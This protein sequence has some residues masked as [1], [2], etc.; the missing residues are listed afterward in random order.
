VIVD[1][2]FIRVAE[3]SGSATFYNDEFEERF[4]RLDGKIHKIVYHF[5]HNLPGS[6]KQISGII[7]CACLTVSIYLID[8]ISGPVINLRGLF[9]IPLLIGAFYFDR[10]YVY[11]NT[12]FI[13]IVV[14][15]SFRDSV[16]PNQFFPFLMTFIP[17]SVGLGL[18]AQFVLMLKTL[19]R[20]LLEHVEDLEGDV[21]E[22]KEKIKR[23]SNKET[24]V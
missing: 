16:F 1:K 22:L 3:L 10:I 9:L 5:L 24:E 13:S 18:T 7:F 2:A 11:I 6:N 15:M 14:T 21:E 12:F 19:I 23:I 17:F 4:S 20:N 8:V